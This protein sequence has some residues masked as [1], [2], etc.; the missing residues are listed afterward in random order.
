MPT[1]VDFRGDP[2]GDLVEV[3][4]GDVL[5]QQ[6]ERFERLVD[7][8]EGAVALDVLLLPRDGRRC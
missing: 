1:S 3:V 4:G 2:I 8:P 5:C 7:D 6:G